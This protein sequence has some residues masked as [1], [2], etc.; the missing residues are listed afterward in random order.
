M[1]NEAVFELYFIVIVVVFIM[2]A[3]TSFLMKLISKCPCVFTFLGF[4]CII[5]KGI[6]TIKLIRLSY[7]KKILILMK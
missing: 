4:N 6:I 2:N 5:N 7:F 3:I 1:K